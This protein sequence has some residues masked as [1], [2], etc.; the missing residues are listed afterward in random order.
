M[1]PRWQGFV[2]EN[3]L[4]Y[5]RLFHL[6]ACRLFRL[7]LSAPRNAQILFRVTKVPVLSLDFSWC[8]LAFFHWC[9]IAKEPCCSPLLTLIW[10]LNTKHKWQVHFTPEQCDKR[11]YF[12]T[13]VVPDQL[14][15]LHPRDWGG[16]G[17]SSLGTP[18]LAEWWVNPGSPIR[19]CR[20]GHRPLL[21]PVTGYCCP[22][23]C[24]GDGGTHL[25]QPANV[26]HGQSFIGMFLCLL[27]YEYKISCS[28]TVWELEKWKEK[29][30]I[31]YLH[32]F[33][34]EKY[35]QIIFICCIHYCKKVKR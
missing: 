33:S 30:C 20:G 21:H 18:I 2:A 24:V 9:Y 10:M 35:P 16:S 1:E 17:W 31:Y 7:D 29:A 15:L 5:T 4:F 23:P 26:Q 28:D 14:E 25:C 22:C 12:P 13:G 6:L 19:A 27:M 8:N 11:A 34:K 32:V 3:L